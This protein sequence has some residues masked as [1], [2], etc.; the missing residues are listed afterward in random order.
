[1]V[2]PAIALIYVCLFTVA[3]QANPSLLTSSGCVERVCTQWISGSHGTGN[4]VAA[5]C[6]RYEIR[7]KPQCYVKPA[8]NGLNLPTQ[9]K[10]TP[11]IIEGGEAR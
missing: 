11:A 1:M 8:P 10:F 9:R 2:R 3:A 7:V 5:Y 4:P 6:E